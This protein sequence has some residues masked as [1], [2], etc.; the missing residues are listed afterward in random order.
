M[1]MPVNLDSN[2]AEEHQERLALLEA[3]AVILYNNRNDCIDVLKKLKEALSMIFFV[4]LFNPIGYILESTLR[5]IKLCQQTDDDI[6]RFV[7]KIM[8]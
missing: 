8:L 4:S 2:Y 5:N 6:Q 1:N 7:R 3:N